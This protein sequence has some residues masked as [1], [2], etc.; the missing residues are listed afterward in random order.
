M[1]NNE[2]QKKKDEEFQTLQQNLAVL[3]D[4]HNLREDSY[5]R[6]QNLYWLARIAAAIEKLSESTEFSEEENEEE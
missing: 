5:Y 6:Q 4:L 1:T 2:E 3:Q